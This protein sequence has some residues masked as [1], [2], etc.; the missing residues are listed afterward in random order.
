M[1]VLT[2]DRNRLTGPIPPELGNLAELSVLWLHQNHLGGPIP[3]ELGGLTD[4][5]SLLLSSNSLEGRIPSELGNLTRLE[6]L[7]LVG[8]ALSGPIPS[9]LAS[10]SSLQAL[11]LNGNDLTGPIPSELGDL[12]ALQSLWLSNNRLTGP[13][14]SE[15]GDLRALQ[16]LLLDNNELTGP[17]PAQLGNLARLTRLELDNNNLTGSVPPELGRLDALEILWLNSNDLTGSIPPELGRLGALES[18]WLDENELTGPIP[19]ELGNLTNLT[20]LDLFD[21]QLTGSIP[22]ELGRLSALELLL[23]SNNELTGPIPVEFGNLAS[24]TRLWLHENQ[25]TGSIPVELG[26]LVNLENLGLEQN[27]L[28]G[29]VPSEFG[30]LTSLEFVSFANNAGMAGPIP[31]ALS[32]LTGLV[33]FLA[34]GTDLCVPSDEQLLAWLESILARRIARCADRER[35]MAYLTQAVQSRDFPVPLVADKEALLRV[36]PTARQATTETLPE[37]RARFFLN[38]DETHVADISPKSTPIPTGFDE[39]DLSKSANAVIPGHLVQPGLEMVIE[40][41]PN[42][43]LD[44][45]LG[46]PKRIPETGRLTVDVLAMPPL[47]LTLIPF[48]FRHE[49]D[50]S[51]VSLVRDIAADPA[52]HEML[53][54]ARLLLP[55]DDLDVTAHEP[56]LTLA[57][58]VS[59]LLLE[60]AIIRIIEGRSGHYMGMMPRAPGERERSSFSPGRSSVSI[61]VP[62]LVA[63]SLG[64]NMWMS[65]APCG[66]TRNPDAS[67]PY[68]GGTIGAWGY[69]A[70]GDG[71]LVPPTAAGFISDCAPP[72]WVSDYSFSNAVRFRAST[73]D[74]ET[75]F[76]RGPQTRTIVV[77]GGLD[78]EGVPFLEPTFVVDA[79]ASLPEAAG[80]YRISGLTADGAELFSLSFDMPELEGGEASVFA[81][82]VPVQASW[83]GRLDRITLSGSGGSATLNADGDRATAILRDRR[84]G[85]VRGILRDVPVTGA[86]EA[87]AIAIPGAGADLEVFLSRG[88]PD[89]EAWRR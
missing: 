32:A 5:T 1:N 88:I 84:T 35:P 67:F 81:F 69:D 61:A 76:D 72:F 11:A 53:E 27:N 58:G 63:S 60:T 51:L 31:S 65:I 28:T 57:G 55:I 79:H 48:I 4:L 70:R 29:P 42:G 38:G 82:A 19:S 16:L 37:V 8:N 3:P 49:G 66:S 52:G 54:Y 33:G 41:D 62:R 39:G 24:L 2:L 12:G 83:A 25:L 50:S 56:V 77:S 21:N 64:V 15:L 17:I 44:P 40:I 59:E 13:I 7:G 87:N 71:S 18:L 74:N 46:V 6:Q 30:R 36:F 20:R 9:E 89:A 73:Y 14:P 34:G 23:L 85:E 78:E 68:R 43:T 10:L 75:L 22:P 45:E 86:A 80:D 47:D 26:N